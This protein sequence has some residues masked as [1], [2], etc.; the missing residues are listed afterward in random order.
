MA[1]FIHSSVRINNV[2][3]G[4][5]KIWTDKER[6]DSHRTVNSENHPRGVD[7]DGNKETDRTY[8]LVDLFPGIKARYTFKE[9]VRGSLVDM[10]VTD[11]NTHKSFGLQIATAELSG[12]K[13]DFNKIV[14]PV[15][16]MHR[17]QYSH[18]VDRSHQW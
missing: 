3:Y 15:Y 10:I 16:Q 12:G 17:Q 11:K 14:R 1:T 5:T 13:F 9:T 6:Q 7:T 4:T 8:S 2:L 18:Y